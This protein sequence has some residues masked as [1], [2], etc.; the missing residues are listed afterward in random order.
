M[1]ERKSHFLFREGWRGWIEVDR[2]DHSQTGG[3]GKNER[4]SQAE[5]VRPTANFIFKKI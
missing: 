2:A 3:N 4:Q 5:E 1:R